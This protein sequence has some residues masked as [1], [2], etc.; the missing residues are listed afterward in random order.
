MAFDKQRL[1][2]SFWQVV[3][4]AEKFSC[5][6]FRIAITMRYST[7]PQQF[8]RLVLFVLDLASPRLYFRRFRLCFRFLQSPLWLQPL[9]HVFRHQLNAP[10]FPEI[11]LPPAF[12][13]NRISPKAEAWICSKRSNPD[14]GRC[15]HGSFTCDRW[16]LVVFCFAVFSIFDLR[17]A[18][19]FF[20][21]SRCCF[22]ASFSK[23]CI[24]QNVASLLR[25]NDK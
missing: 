25:R 18:I 15:S 9:P 12:K 16:L 5:K 11:S 23:L 10:R 4:V 19:F 7:V 8:Q 1:H 21:F 17:V 3:P 20:R 24:P 14:L 2:N 6:I 22:G 13:Q